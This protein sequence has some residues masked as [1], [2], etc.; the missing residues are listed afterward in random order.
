MK[1]TVLDNK[2]PEGFLKR[3]LPVK[4]NMRFSVL[5]VGISFVIANIIIIFATQS[6]NLFLRY[7]IGEF[8]LYEPAPSTFVLDRDILWTDEDATQKERDKAAA[9][10]P[11]VF[12]MSDEISAECLKELVGFQ[13]LMM[14]QKRGGRKPV[15]RAACG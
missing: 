13:S 2:S 4:K 8:K 5:I 11:L 3:I 6:G 12:R 7:N 15:I 1:K 14:G 10:E 9:G